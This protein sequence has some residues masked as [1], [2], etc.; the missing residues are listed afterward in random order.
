VLIIDEVAVG[1]LNTLW[2]TTA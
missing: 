1:F 2:R